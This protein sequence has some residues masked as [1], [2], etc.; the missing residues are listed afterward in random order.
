MQCVGRLCC[1]GQTDQLAGSHDATG[2]FC[3]EKA[4][5]SPHRSLG[6][7]AHALSRG[8]AGITW[9]RW[10][11]RCSRKQVPSCDQNT[12]HHTHGSAAGPGTLPTDPQRLT[13]RARNYFSQRV[14][15]KS[16]GC[17]HV[18]KAIRGGAIKLAMKK[19]DSWQP[20]AL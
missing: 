14:E 7:R 5:L 9:H 16:L 13:V 17:H 8:V 2:S 10:G 3:L 6:G 12:A 18:N 4:V 20:A 15:T 11:V 1:S 19:S